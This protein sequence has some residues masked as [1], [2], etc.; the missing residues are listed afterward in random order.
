MLLLGALSFML[1]TQSGSQWALARAVANLND[2]GAMSIEIDNTQGTIL[3]GLSFGRVRVVN[4]SATIVVRDLRTSWNPYSLLWGQLLLSDL[5]MSSLRVELAEGEADAEFD[6]AGIGNPLPVAIRVSSLRVE[7]LELVQQE[8]TATVR[9]ISLGTSLNDSGLEL[10]ALEFAAQGAEIS[11]E[12]EILFTDALDLSAN[13]NWNYS[14]V[15]DNR[16]EELIGTLEANGDIAN[17]SIDHQLDSPQRIHS[18]GSLATGLDGSE[19]GFDLVHT[20]DVATVPIEVPVNYALSNVSLDT[21]GNLDSVSLAL[22][23]NVQYEQYPSALIETQA[24]YADSV[25]DIRSFT[26]TEAENSVSGAA[27]FDWSGTPSIEGSYSLQLQSVDTYIDL[28]DSIALA[29]IV[30]A[31]S[32]DLVFPDGGTEGGLVVDSFDGRLAGYPLQGQ[33]SLFFSEGALDIDAVELRTQN[34]RLSLDGSYADTV[35]L[36]WSLSV[37]SLGEF[38]V[39]GSGVLEGRGRLQ[40]NPAEPDITG[41]LT[42]SGIGY[43]QIDVSQFEFAFERVGGQVASE[44]AIDSFTYSDAAINE[45]LSAIELLATGSQTDHMINFSARSKFGNLSAELSGGVSDSQN[46]IWQ[47]V[48]EDASVDTPVGTWLSRGAS[49]MRIATAEVELSESC[50]EQGDA[51]LCFAGLNDLDGE[52]T[53]N[54]SIEGYPLSIFNSGAALDVAAGENL[55]IDQ[56]LVLPQLPVGSSMTGRVGG[57]FTLSQSATEDLQLDFQLAASDA[58]L[59]IIPEQMESAENFNED[60]APQEYKLEILELS[61]GLLD[62]AWQLSTEAGILRENLDDS[63]ID[64]R[65]EISAD[66]GIAADYGINGTVSAGLADLRWL[67][68]VV[69]EFSDLDGSLRA[70][71]ALGGSIDAPQATGSID[72]DDASV[73]IEALGITLTGVAVNVSSDDPALIQVTGSAESNEG[74]IDFNGEIAEPFG[75]MPTLSAEVRGND[76]QLA[77][78]PNL[79]LLISPDVVVKFDATRI[80]VNGNIDIETLNLTLEELP[81]TAV[82]VSRD[83]VIVSYPDDRPDLARSIAANEASAFDLPLTGEVDITL[84]DDVNFVGFGMTTKLAGNLNIQQTLGGSNRTYGEL[85]IV[86]GTY[87]MYRQSLNISQGKLLFFGAYDNPGIDLRATREVEGFTVGV[88]MNGTLKNVNSQLFSTPALADNDIISVLVTGRPFS[89]I[90]QQDGDGDAVLAAIAKLGVGRSEGLTNQVRNKLGLDVLSVDPTDDINNSVLT[91]GK[92]ITPDIFIRYGVGLFDSQSK[93]AVDYTLSER[94]KLKAESGEY[95]SVDVIYS[96]ER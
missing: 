60:P 75:L 92:Y 27:I 54:G 64:V 11:G 68:A 50:W 23:A 70:Q 48:L 24:N 28:P 65:G 7:R 53:A 40:G 58:F 76:F 90:G 42:S 95:Q 21:T 18:T 79:E 78:I 77:D 10:S 66:V 57:Q 36:S 67:Q 71:A 84:G 12:I 44:L 87:E 19:F 72:L 55:V 51:T 38:L 94:L 56:L 31:G 81:E 88:L 35:D 47:G 3:R 61:G 85:S 13:L 96:V 37:D 1:S 52:I 46:L 91:I 32:Y 74:S 4:E 89:E 6:L 26:L 15:L 5:W 39:G 63:E 17:L 30:G 93:L 62:G 9:S 43:Q 82:D 14:L 34:N 59:Q 22:F 45:S 33:G 20:A 25:L 80:E 8:Q 73:T 29:D 49:A 2:S 16:V 41:L 83:V 86:E 69:P